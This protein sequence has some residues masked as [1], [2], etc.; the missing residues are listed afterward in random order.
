M[1]PVD[2]R[3]VCHTLISL[4]VIL[5]VL[6]VD[7]TFVACTCV[8]S[9]RFFLHFLLYIII[10]AYIFP[11]SC[12][13]LFNCIQKYVSR[14][15]AYKILF[16]MH[17]VCRI[18][19]YIMRFVNRKAFA[20]DKRKN[21]GQRISCTNGVLNLIVEFFWTSTMTKRFLFYFLLLIFSLSFFLIF[22]LVLGFFFLLS[23]FRSTELN[24]FFGIGS[25][26]SVYISK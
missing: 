19:T 17:F 16:W 4:F 10:T 23:I 12:V 21:K 13:S 18:G 9:C 7:V 11:F 15:G 8:Y 3:N 1:I 6:W 2:K 24:A 20:Y 5:I 22:V 26:M 14:V 25:D